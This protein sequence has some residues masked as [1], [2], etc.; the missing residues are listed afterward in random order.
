M[1]NLSHHKDKSI[2][3][4]IMA[5][6]ALQILAL[7]QI[8]RVTLNWFFWTNVFSVD[9]SKDCS[10]NQICEVSWMRLV[11]WNNAPTP[12]PRWTK[13]KFAVTITI[14]N[15]FLPLYTYPC[16]QKIGLISWALNNT[17]SNLPKV[18]VFFAASTEVKH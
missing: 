15:S 17:K 16:F 12:P 4:N 7:W 1:F 5:T 6:S 9:R 2:H 3:C 14:N 8:S 18:Y 11:S 13:N 10:G